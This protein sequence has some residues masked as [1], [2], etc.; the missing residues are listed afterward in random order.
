LYAYSYIFI[1]FFLLLATK[2][3][4]TAKDLAELFL[5]GDS[6]L[7]SDKEVNEFK[8]W[9]THVK[10]VFIDY[11]DKNQSRI[12]DNV[13]EIIRDKLGLH[14]GYNVEVLFSWYQICLDLKKNDAIELIKKFLSCNGRIKYIKSLYFK[15]FSFNR[16]EAVAFFKENK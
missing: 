9:H 8:S 10:L 4:Q 5:K 3:I 16:E 6:S 7:V 12:S 15:F 1:T 13:Y 14:S 2:S 11:L